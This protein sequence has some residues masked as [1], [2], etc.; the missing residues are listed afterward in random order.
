MRGLFFGCMD[1]MDDSDIPMG[2][3]EEQRA[4]AEA[5]ITSIFSCG[6]AMLDDGQFDFNRAN[7][8]DDEGMI[9]PEREVKK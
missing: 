7:G 6:G 2:S 1:S 8:L 5:D 3:P 4:Q 9:P